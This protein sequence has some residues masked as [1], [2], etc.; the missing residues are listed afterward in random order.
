MKTNGQRPP[1]R[2]TEQHKKQHVHLLYPTEKIVL[3]L[4]ASKGMVAVAARTLGCSRST[5]YDAQ[6]RDPRVAEAIT[7]E[8]ELALDV[9]ELKLAQ[10]IDQGELGAICFFLKCQGRE[11]GYI[12]RI[13]ANHTGTVTL[14][15]LVT[16][17]YEIKESA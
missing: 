7:A 14:E 3:A 2:H 11:R 10:L 5:I 16:G 6:Q 12:E 1:A 15:K 13:D 9:A 8:R 4:H 17:S